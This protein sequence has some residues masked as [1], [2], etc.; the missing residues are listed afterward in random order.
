MF[1]FLSHA[2]SPVH[3]QGDL[4][5]EADGMKGDTIK[6]LSDDDGSRKRGVPCGHLE[7]HIS[8][9]SLCFQVVSAGTS[10]MARLHFGR[11]TTTDGADCVI[12]FDETAQ[13][14]SH[15]GVDGALGPGCGFFVSLENE[16][17]CF[18]FFQKIFEGVGDSTGPHHECLFSDSE[19]IHVGSSCPCSQK[20]QSG[21]GDRRETRVS[22][23]VTV[24]NPVQ[25]GATSLISL[26]LWPGA[27]WTSSR[28]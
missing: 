1:A 5:D 9:D 10:A 6:L 16:D 15:A 18:F 12:S 24:W 4:G 7:R 13:M 14:L 26:V 21:E 2:L 19:Q 23:D 28:F 8:Q 20:S 25:H 17:L 27:V 22:N 3:L 11:R